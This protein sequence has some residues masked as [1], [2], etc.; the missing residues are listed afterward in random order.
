MYE[1]FV[2]D[3]GWE[4]LESVRSKTEDTDLNC[5]VVQTKRSEAVRMHEHFVKDKS[6]EADRLVVCI[7]AMDCI[8]HMRSAFVNRAV[9]LDWVLADLWS[10]QN[11]SSRL[12]YW[13]VR[14]HKMSRL[15]SH[16]G[17]WKYGLGDHQALECDHD[18]PSPKHLEA[19]LQ[20]DAHCHDRYRLLRVLCLSFFATL[21]V[22]ARP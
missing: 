7:V 13:V 19:A 21:I 16:R 8:R 20:K 14:A 17:D 1:H 22:K 5:S 15:Y 9:G 4:S 10:C 18:V 11:R 3:K 2:I 6:S 12:R